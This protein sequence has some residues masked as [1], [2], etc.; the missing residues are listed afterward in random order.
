LSPQVAFGII[1]VVLVITGVYLELLSGFLRRAGSLT[2]TD[3]T[4]TIGQIWAKGNVQAFNDLLL[5]FERELVQDRGHVAGD[6]GSF[7]LF[8]SV[9]SGLVINFPWLE[10]F[11]YVIVFL[12]LT[13][14][15]RVVWVGDVQ[16]IRKRQRMQNIFDALSAEHKASA[17]YFGDRHPSLLQWSRLSKF[18]RFRSLIEQVRSTAKMYRRVESAQP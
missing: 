4:G 3:M 2:D 13:I 8:D 7:V 14:A 10:Y 16:L 1:T 9:L 11:G 12:V 17:N 5:A 6:A 18:A 15:I